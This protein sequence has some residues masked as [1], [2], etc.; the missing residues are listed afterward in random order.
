MQVIGVDPGRFKT[1]IWYAGGHFEF[2][3]SLGEY[4]ESEFDDEKG[5]DDLIIEYNGMKFSGGT[6]A[7]RESEYGGP[8]MTDSKLHDDTL[9][10]ILVALHKAFKSCEVG[11]VT[12]LPVADHK[13]DKILL[14]SMLTGYHEITVNGVTKW[15]RIYASVAPEGSC[16]FKYADK[17]T[18]RGLQVGSRT[19]NAIT[20]KDGQKIGKESDTF[21]F[22]TESG[23]NRDSSAIARATIANTGS[24]KWKK[25][26]LLFLC[27]GG[28]T[29]VYNHI[30]RY[31]RNANMV[32]N[33]VFSD[34]EAFY[35]IA[36]E[37]YG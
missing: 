19:V 15:F 24:L 32:L 28:S 21:D 6:L 1:K 20:F 22:G 11:L 4:R 2:Y 25:D 8:M 34:S 29:K 37:I 27:G 17:G 26:D 9:I 18:V 3:S 33:P 5:D 12:G 30:K 23:K 35:Y 13:R 31:Y 36:R 16:F 7:I 14:S 10:L